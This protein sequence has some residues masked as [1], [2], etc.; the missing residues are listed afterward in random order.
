MLDAVGRALVQPSPLHRGRPAL[1]RPAD[2]SPGHRHADPPVRA[3]A[4][5]VREGEGNEAERLAL[6]EAHRETRRR[7]DRGDPAEPRGHR[8]QDRPLPRKDRVLMQQRIPLGSAGPR[9]LRARASAA[10]A[11]RE[12]YGTADDAES[13]ATIHRALDL[14]VDF[15]DTADMYG[16]PRTRSCVG[17]AIARPPR[18]ASCSRPSSASSAARTATVGAARRP[19]RVRARGVRGAR[20]GGS[21]STTSTS[22]TS[23]ASTR[24]RRSRRPSARW[25]SSCARARCAT[26]ASRRRRRRRSAAPT[27]CT[28][29]PRCRPSTR[30]G[31]ATPEDEI[32]PDVRELGIGFVP[33]SPLGRGFLTGDPARSRIS[34]PDD[35]RRARPALPGR[36]LRSGTCEL[37]DARRAS[38]RA[39]RA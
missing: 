2:K 9:R 4:A 34:P 37:V 23:T 39:R 32:L 11:C 26:S 35:F 24:R 1:A 5:L 12:F 15:L 30:C 7:A 27:P 10:W 21:A 6:L 3:Y 18:R 36:E 31:P 8:P 14:G 19:A 20:C 38:R 13:I 33:Y 22:T 29:S 28:R 17:R 16:P 25:P